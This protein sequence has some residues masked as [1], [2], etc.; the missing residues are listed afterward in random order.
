VKP[1]RQKKRKRKQQV[2]EEAKGKKRKSPGWKTKFQ[3]ADQANVASPW[4]DLWSAALSRYLDLPYAAD[5]KARNEL[6][7]A[8]W[9]RSGVFF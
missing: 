1:C 8:G 2:P 9:E 3:C 7:E 5:R 6:W 4:K